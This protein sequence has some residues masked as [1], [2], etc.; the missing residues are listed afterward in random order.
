MQFQRT[1]SLR[2]AAAE[3]RRCA[4]QTKGGAVMK[5]LHLFAVALLMPLAALSEGSSNP[6]GSWVVPG[7]KCPFTFELTNGQIKRTTGT[8]I[9]S[10]K[11]KLIEAGEGWL[12]DEQLDKS[13]DGL[14]C[15]GQNASV[16]ARH[17]KKQAY[18]EV[19]GDTL[20]YFR[21]K[22]EELAHSFVRRI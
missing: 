6:E 3:L 13:N 4:S 19:K 17:L 7:S 14:S 16:V 18:I 8:L 2:S 12:L 15:K 1:A 5:V 11:V 20:Y 22:G 21:G 9:Y 10:T